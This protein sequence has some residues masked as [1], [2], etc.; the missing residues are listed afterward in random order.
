MSMRTLAVSAF[1]AGSL[2]TQVPLSSAAAPEKGVTYT[3][4]PLN[5]NA[6]DSVAAAL[7]GALCSSGQCVNIRHPAALGDA[8]IQAGTD[9]LDSTLRGDAYTSVIVAGQSQGAQ[10]ATRWIE[11]HGDSFAPEESVTFVLIANPSRKTGFQSQNG[12]TSPTTED[13]RYTII[14]IARE[15][16]GWAHWPDR[17]NLLAIVNATMGM[18]NVHTTYEDVLGAPTT[19]EEIQQAVHDDPRG[20]RNLVWKSGGTY[21]VL[22]RTEILPIAVPL[23]WVGL[24]TTARNL[25]DALRPTIDEAYDN[26]EQGHGIGTSD[27]GSK[28]SPSVT[29][30]SRTPAHEALPV[31]AENT[32]ETR[33]VEHEHRTAAEVSATAPPSEEGAPPSV[34]KSEST[35]SRAA[36]ASK[37]DERAE[38]AARAEAK[39]AERDAKR[40]ERQSE[41]ELRAGSTAAEPSPV[42]T[43]IRESARESAHEP[44]QGDRQGSDNDAHDGK[45]ADNG[46][47]E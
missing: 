25:S 11:T 36:L 5:Y 12:F 23:T 42:R 8:S 7:G 34:E 21:Y 45:R 15:Y 39:K 35:V 2:V 41:R 30:A 14:D 26:P 1:L 22:N 18:F 27:V 10:S 28:D 6:E 20:E 37:E 24:N 29:Q 19:V 40:E 16:D 13:S 32:S 43:D 38:R 47:D 9:N 44:A 31:K 33:D 4:Q 46:A 17:L 3:L